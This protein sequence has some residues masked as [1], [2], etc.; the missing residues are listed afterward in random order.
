MRPPAAVLALVA[1]L[2][3]AAPSFAHPSYLPPF[4]D[5]APEVGDRWLY[6]GEALKASWRI[7][8]LEVSEED[9]GWRVLVEDQIDPGF[10]VPVQRVEWMLRADGSIWREKSWWQGEPSGT[11]KPLLVVA[12]LPT[13]HAPL[14]FG[15]VGWRG[16]GKRRGWMGTAFGLFQ[17]H[18]PLQQP[19]WFRLGEKDHPT[20]YVVD[21]PDLGRVRWTDRHDVDWQLVS[22]VI[23]GVSWEP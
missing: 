16:N 22:A 15:H 1:A 14:R 5:R 2:A 9:G 18:L 8:V 7:E 23:G 12:E 20:L 3:G 6:F 21:D 10:V 13:S 4:L 17:P 11:R 19:Y